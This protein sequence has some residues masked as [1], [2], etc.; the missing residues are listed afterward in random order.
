MQTAMATPPPSPQYHAAQLF[1][2]L[3]ER[4]RQHPESFIAAESARSA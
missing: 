2:T 1:L 4:V 3:V